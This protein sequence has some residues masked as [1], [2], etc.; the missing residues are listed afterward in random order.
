M[1][2]PEESGQVD[3]FGNPGTMP[4]EPIGLAFVAGVA[5]DAAER[6]RESANEAASSLE[7]RRLSDAEE[8]IQQAAYRAEEA[9]D[10]LDELLDSL[11]PD[12]PGSLDSGAALLEPI[13]VAEIRGI[14]AVLTM[15]WRAVDDDAL[16]PSAQT[17]IR[18]MAE[19]ISATRDE[20]VPD[21]TPRWKLVGA[22]RSAMG[23]L[24]VGLPATVIAW[25]KALPVLLKIHWNE[26]ARLL[27][28]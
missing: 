23:Y 27:P 19:M 20:A 9:R 7:L 28:G 6:A 5:R 15:L 16:P 25:D 24:G 21:K 11:E 8:E 4:P 1:A 26:V 17:Q 3:L 18:A 10:G 2:R 13:T 12:Q 22:V 14:E